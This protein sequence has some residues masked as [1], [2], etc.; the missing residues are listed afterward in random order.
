M[1][2]V[3]AVDRRYL[4][5]M[6]ASI[7]S[8]IA[9]SPKQNI[10]FYILHNTVLPEQAEQVS[11]YFNSASVTLHFM[12]VKA[13]DVKDLQVPKSEYEA[14]N[15]FTQA[16]YYRLL[17]P[18][19]MPEHVEK[20]IYLDADT[21]VC[22]DLA[23][24]WSTDLG[25]KPLA[26][27]AE[28]YS[29]T[30]PPHFRYNHL[31]DLGITDYYFNSGVLV[32]DVAQLRGANFLEEASQVVRDFKL[33]FPDQDV[34]N[35]LFQHRTCFLPP[36]FNAMSCAGQP[37]ILNFLRYFQLAGKMCPYTEAQIFEAANKPHIVHFFGK[38]KPWH[39]PGMYFAHKE[40]FW[41]YYNKTLY[42]TQA[43]DLIEKLLIQERDKERE[44]EKTF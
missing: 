32:F 27:V 30:D 4:E 33:T 40:I 19:M 1:N 37:T 28:P 6:A 31:N 15:Y 9:H 3:Y 17:I 36:K 38:Y 39:L 20:A 41:H 8:V 2:I 23:A 13:Q 12:K 14:F 10:H 44:K 42:R 34:L 11:N 35:M 29:P 25:G 26:A 16:I 21:I 18:A 24:L 5:A 43:S 22:Q 7:A